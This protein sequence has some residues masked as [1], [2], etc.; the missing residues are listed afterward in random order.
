MTTA[1]LRH[2]HALMYCEDTIIPG[3]R[4]QTRET[5]HLQFTSASMRDP[6]LQNTIM[7]RFEAFGFLSRPGALLKGNLTF[8]ENIPFAFRFVN[9]SFKSCSSLICSANKPASGEGYNPCFLF[10]K[11]YNLLKYLIS[12]EAP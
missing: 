10:R 3:H 11:L 7:R 4:E 6:F 2:C 5:L 8:L 9:I 12:R 1:P